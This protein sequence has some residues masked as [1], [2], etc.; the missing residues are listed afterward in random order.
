MVFG[1]AALELT[2]DPRDVQD[3][4][5]KAELMKAVNRLR[6]DYREVILLFYYQNCTIEQ[7]AQVLNVPS[8]TVSSRLTRG[9]QKLR[10]ILEG[11]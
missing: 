4:L 5:E 2:P 6:P 3:G 9:R 11:K 8:G 10:E 7:I 1:S